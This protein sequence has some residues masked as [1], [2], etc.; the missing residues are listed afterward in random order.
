MGWE[1]V[2]GIEDIIDQFLG[3]NVKTVFSTIGP[4]TGMSGGSESIFQDENTASIK[5]ILKDENDL[6]YETIRGSMLMVS[7]SGTAV[8]AN[9]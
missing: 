9:K 7:I 3:D 8:V 6:D 1:T 5:I 2:R 4:V